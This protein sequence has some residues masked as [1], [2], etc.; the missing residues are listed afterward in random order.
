[1]IGAEIRA[2]ICASPCPTRRS[3]PC[4]AL[5]E[6]LVLF[7]GD[8]TSPRR[9]NWPSPAFRPPVCPWWRSGCHRPHRS[10]LQ[11]AGG[12]SHSPQSGLLHTDVAFL[13]APPDIA[14]LS[15]QDTPPVAATRCGSISTPC[16]TRCRPRS[17]TSCRCSICHSIWAN[18]SAWR[19]GHAGREGVPADCGAGA[20]DTPPVGAY[21]P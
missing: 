18:R 17:K 16:T 12:R 10:V 5:L 14:V 8:R 3:P 1:V 4:A 9:S 13:P 2:S 11:C 7:F 15:M 6:H 20:G 19:D 21:P